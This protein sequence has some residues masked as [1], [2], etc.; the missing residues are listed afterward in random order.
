MD[1]EEANDKFDA[2]D[3]HLTITKDLLRKN[4]WGNSYVVLKRSIETM[5]SKLNIPL[6]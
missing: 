6:Y 2:I 4:V 3:P 1:L 5:I